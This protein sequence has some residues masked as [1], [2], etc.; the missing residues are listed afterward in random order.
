[1]EDQIK[2]QFENKIKL[3]YHNSMIRLILAILNTV[4]LIV[5]IVLC[6]KWFGW[7]MVIV[8]ILISKLRWRSSK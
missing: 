5:G 6:V 2:N 4:T 1:M 7:K 3:Q 8:I